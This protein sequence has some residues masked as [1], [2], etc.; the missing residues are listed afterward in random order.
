MTFNTKILTTAGLLLLLTS[1]S[2]VADR[3]ERSEQNREKAE[4]WCEDYS[5][6]HGSAQ[7][8]V[9]KM[10]K[11]CPKGMHR[12]KRFKQFRSRGYKSCIPGSKAKVIKQVIK[13]SHSM[14]A[15]A[16]WKLGEKTTKGIG[17]VTKKSTKKTA[18]FIKKSTRFGIEGI[19]KTTPIPD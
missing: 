11:L 17:K 15:K 10:P 3:A 1:Q 16:G 9:V 6:S 13:N 5:R 8:R 7:C 2:A 12:G 4:A 19:K 14:P 18:K